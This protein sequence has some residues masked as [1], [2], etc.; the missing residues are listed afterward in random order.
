MIQR[1][2]SKL[3][4]VVAALVVFVGGHSLAQDTSVHGIIT[5]RTGKT[6]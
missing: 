3:A 5:G 6:P 4:V 1:S 2:V